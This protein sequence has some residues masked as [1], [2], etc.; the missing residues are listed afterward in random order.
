MNQIAKTPLVSSGLALCPGG[1]PQ[2]SSLCE[3]AMQPHEQRVLDE[4]EALDEKLS[5]L[6]AFT[7]T[8]TFSNLDEQN[9]TLLLKQVD[10]MQQYSDIL[11]A[12]IE[13]F[14]KEKA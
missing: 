2:S 3:G 9:T 4:K 8:E 13:L 12:R 7:G 6:K 5:K 11:A 14:P 1:L 10:A